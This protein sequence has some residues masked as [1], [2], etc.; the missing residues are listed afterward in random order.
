M[1]RVVKN[2]SPS[3]RILVLAAQASGEFFTLAMRAGADGYLT[4]EAQPME[5]INAIRCV[6]AGQ[7]YVNASIVTLLVSTLVC[8]T[9]RRA[10][11]D[12]Y[13]DLS[14]REKE[15]LCLAASGHT[16]NEI[17]EIL[18]LSKRTVHNVRARLME[19]LGLHDR[20]ELL[21]YALRRGIVAAGDI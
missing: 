7:N 12:S 1:I 19:K 11:G 2:D 20:M 4:R 16:N 6:S 14:G 9:R 3:T 15:I 17:A 13:E 10:L 5:I 18:R 8:G 21:K